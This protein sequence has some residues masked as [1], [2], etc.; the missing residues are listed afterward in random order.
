MFAHACRLVF[1]AAIAM[2]A[3]AARADEIEVGKVPEAARKAADGAIADKTGLKNVK[4]T[5]AEQYTEA[6][7][8]KYDLEGETPDEYGAFVTVTAGGVV[9]DVSEEVDF[10]KLPAAVLKAVRAAVPGLKEDEASV[11]R[12]LSG[13]NLADVSFEIEGEDAKGKY[14]WLDATP[15]GTIDEFY[16]EIPTKDLPKQVFAAFDKMFPKRKS[17]TC[18]AVQVKG[19]L[20]R[21]DI[22]VVRGNDTETSVS[23]TPAGRLIKD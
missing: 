14:V 3:S 11:H 7:V 23:F 4:W 22:E 20:A 17:A 5:K 9:E 8:V 1:A 2:T 18:Y 21:Y 13:K 10:A 15:D 6:N 12:C 19:K 16:S